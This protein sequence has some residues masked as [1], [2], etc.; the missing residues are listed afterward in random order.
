MSSKNDPKIQGPTSSEHLIAGGSSEEDRESVFLLMNRPA[1]KNTETSPAKPAKPSARLIASTIVAA[2]IFTGLAALYFMRPDQHLAVGVMCGIAA[3]AFILWL[4]PKWQVAWITLDSSNDRFAVE[5]EA[6]K[7]VA[8]VLGGL[9]FLVG[10]YF[11][12]ENLTA[13][14][15]NL[16]GTQE[17]GEKARE[18]TRLGQL[19]ERFA[20]A[21]EQLLKKET[22]ESPILGSYSL[23]QIALESP[24]SSKAV[25]QALTVYIRMNSRWSDSK[26]RPAAT[27]RSDTSL[28]AGVQA[29]LLQLR[30]I[31][32]KGA[33]SDEPQKAA[34]YREALSNLDL[35]NTDLRGADLTSM[36][37]DGLVLDGAH[38]NN[39][40]LNSSILTNATLIKADVAG[41]DL[42]TTNLSEALLNGAN[43]KGATFS[44]SSHLKQLQLDSACFDNDDALPPELG[45]TLPTE[46]NA[47]CDSW[48]RK[49]PAK[50]RTQR[51]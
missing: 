35:S 6:R 24:Q 49:T 30:E 34:I 4:L 15:Q 28:S 7:T 44:A 43:L 3:S 1:A 47:D 46:H 29:A 38:L 20:R 36:W 12:A 25:A 51:R 14:Q 5:N 22:V 48:K 50:R 31:S 27:D 33:L 21:Y 45:F 16:M 26:K 32:R 40:K 42:S 19:N 17:A 37:L 10:F 23:G 13:T 2:L 39:A 9:I 11:T 41:V 8:Q 18:L